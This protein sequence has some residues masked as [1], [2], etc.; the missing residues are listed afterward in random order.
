MIGRS[1]WKSGLEVLL[2][3]WLK[4]WDEVKIKVVVVEGGGWLMG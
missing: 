2:E 4:G 3:R 1:G